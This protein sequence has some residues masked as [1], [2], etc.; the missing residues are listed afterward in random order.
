MLTCG[1]AGNVALAVCETHEETA[2]AGVTT[3]F[4]TGLFGSSTDVTIEM[5]LK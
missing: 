4:I 3:G 1:V 2:G 5:K